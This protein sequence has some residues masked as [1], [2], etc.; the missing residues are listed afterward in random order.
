M[1][2]I[3]MQVVVAGLATCAIVV[4]SSAQVEAPELVALEMRSASRALDAVPA[5]FAVAQN[6]ENIKVDVSVDSM[7][8]GFRDLAGQGDVQDLLAAALGPYD[9]EGYDEWAGTIRT[10]FAVY[11]FVRSNGP[12][13]PSVGR[14]MQQVLNDPSIP[15]SQKDAIVRLMNEPMAQPLEADGL[16]PTQENLT[17]V[18]ALVPHIEATVEMMRVMQ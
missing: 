11:S 10:V 4:P 7:M 17:V 9:F 13:A 2:R 14:A 12:S 18:I 1:M 5:V 15:Q 8:S 6:L 16:S 3:A